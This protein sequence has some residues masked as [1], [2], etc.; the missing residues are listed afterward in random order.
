MFVPRHETKP[1]FYANPDALQM[2]FDKNA[3][4]GGQ[5]ICKAVLLLT[6]FIIYLNDNWVFGRLPGLITLPVLCGR[7]NIR[8]FNR[9]FKMDHK[10]QFAPGL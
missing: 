4:T 10:R 7:D 1:I 9:T 5:T 3:T 2:I 8:P 6:T